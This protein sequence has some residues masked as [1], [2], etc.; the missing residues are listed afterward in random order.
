MAKI[1]LPL[2]DPT[3]LHLT[4]EG[5]ERRA[6]RRQCNALHKAAMAIDPKLMSFVLQHCPNPSLE[7]RREVL[8]TISHYCRLDQQS[9]AIEIIST[10]CGME[11]PLVRVFRNF[12]SHCTS[13]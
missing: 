6:V 13:C 8:A 12:A 5:K 10:L 2:T 3:L 11:E 1:I 9:E 4:R 7:V